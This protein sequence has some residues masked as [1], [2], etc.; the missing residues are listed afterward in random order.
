MRIRA[1][2]DN[3]RTDVRHAVRSLRRSPGFAA[4]AILALAVGIGG[5][6]AIFSVIDATRT[7]AIPYREPQQLVY[8]IGTARRAAIERRGASYP[9]FLDW[10]A[11]VTRI[12][13]LAAFDAQLMT[14]AGTDE[15]ERIDTEFV[16]ASYFSLLGVT[17]AVGR[18][19]GPDEDD[20]AKPMAVVLLSDGLWRRRFGSDPQVVGRSITLNSQPFTVVGVMAPGFTGVTDEAQMWIPF[21]QYAPPRTMADRGSRGFTVVGR[22]KPGVTRGAA[23][24]ELDAIA[25]RLERAY[26]KTNEGRGIEVSPLA[27]EVYGTLRVALQ[28]LMGAIALVLVIA[29]ANVANL[30]IARSEAR[31]REIALRVAI[32][33]GRVRL[34]QQLVT[35]S[36]VLTLLGA[37]AS[38]PL[39]DAT[40]RL[41][42]TQSPVTFPSILMPALNARVAA[43]TTTVALICGVCVGLA[44]WWQ[45]RF[46]DLVSRL[47]E[48]SRGSVGPV[49]QRLR[50][51]LVIAEVTLAV[52]LLV[53]ASLMIQSVR[54][55]AAIDP[56]FDAGS[57]LTMHVSVPRVPPPTADGRPASG[58]PA[59]PVATGRELL[60]RIVS[61]PGVVSVGLGNDVPLD[62]NAGANFYSVEGQRPFTA[63]DRPRAWVHRVSPGFFAA[64][65]IPLVAGRT[66]LDTELTPSPSSVIVSEKVA[67]RFW[68]GQDPVGKRLTLGS[69]D[70]NVQW[71]SIVG[72]ARDVRYR[73]LRQNAN[74]DPDIYLP[75]ADRNAQIALAIRTSVPP[76]S[77]VAPVRAAIR[78]ASASIAIY[79]VESMESRVHAQSSRERFTTWVM[80]VFAG[81]ALWLCALGIYG[82]MSYVVTLST[83]EIGI[84]LALGAQPREVLQRIVGSGA[85]LIVTGVA[86]GGLASVALRR[87]VSATILDV[88]LS[89]PAAGLAL[90]LFALVGLAACLVPGLRATRL[91]PVRALQQE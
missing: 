91:D 41:L 69:V 61:V 9:D 75:F 25:G 45:I 43:F 73:T 89:D 63:Q 13:D 79:D 42:V 1:W 48:S 90:V 60:D 27:T 11:Q 35:E 50:N 31:R 49:S 88:P 57:L 2:F 64:L 17:P 30:L 76:S 70:V 12:D 54:K 68:P 59:P 23:Q 7:Q 15:S 37:V 16:S 83:R 85:R 80:S 20:V 28:V 40:I 8:L 46:A 56:G 87:A 82:V 84:R 74:A 86:I 65:Q 26:P 66:F 22:L 21:A 19:F 34:L 14:L 81:I 52:V 62:G 77:V 24:A 4:I 18:T 36:C 55:L 78:A 53:G 47:R 33:A 72:V 32:G 44:P 29:C 38:L 51:G 3:V 10:R 5:N 71:L 6:T 58:T 39:A 67:A